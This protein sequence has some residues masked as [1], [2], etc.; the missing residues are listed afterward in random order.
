MGTHFARVRLLMDALVHA[1]RVYACSTC[2][3]SYEV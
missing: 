1:C 3:N 2:N